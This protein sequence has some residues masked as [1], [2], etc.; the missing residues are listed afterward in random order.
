MMEIFSFFKYEMSTEM[1]AITYLIEELK[2]KSKELFQYACS[3]KSRGAITL[4]YVSMV[5]FVSKR[6]WPLLFV[7]KDDCGEVCLE[8][9]VI[10]KCVNDYNPNESVVVFIMIGIDKKLAKQ[11]RNDAITQTLIIGKDAYKTVKPLY[12]K[13]GKELKGD[14]KKTD[15][16]EIHV[17]L[18]NTCHKKLKRYKKCSACLSAAYCDKQCQRGDWSVHKLVCKSLANQ[19]KYARDFLHKQDN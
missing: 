17:V 9:D 18:C 1:V 19:L 3:F 15:P 11:N 13:N 6:E 12:D 16:T 8:T 7:P 2:Y 10:H 14:W 5:E 4:I